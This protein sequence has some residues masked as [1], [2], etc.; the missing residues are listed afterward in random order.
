MSNTE[1]YYLYRDAD[2]YKQHE[3][4]I[5]PGVLC[6]SD[7]QKLFDALD[8]DDGFVPSA[9]GLD[10]LQ[11]RNVNGW[12]NDVDHPYHELLALK[13]TKKE[14]TI[15]MT[16]LDFYNRIIYCDWEQ[17]ALKVTQSHI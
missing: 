1:L 14:P 16:I 2:N 12:Q 17:E 9:V 7:A 4:V 11:E 15:D 6:T 13:V 8:D 5:M 3:S 10:D